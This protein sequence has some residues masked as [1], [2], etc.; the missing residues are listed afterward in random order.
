MCRLSN[1]SMDSNPWIENVKLIEISWL[2]ESFSNGFRL[3]I[4][5]IPILWILI[6]WI[7]SQDSLATNLVEK[8]SYR[9]NG[10]HCTGAYAR[11]HRSTNKVD[12]G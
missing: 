5:W 9:D 3:I 10:L 2:P 7:D 1:S 11:K 4:V 12:F 6:P 8:L